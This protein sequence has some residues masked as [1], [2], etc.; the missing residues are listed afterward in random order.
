MIQKIKTFILTHKIISI[1]I[2]VVIVVGAYFIFR[3]S[4]GTETRYITEVV[5]KGSITTTVTGTGQIEASDTIT[6]SPK[7]S[8]DV[9]YV[10]VK[11]GDVVKKGKLLMS[12]DS[13]SAK[14][15]LDN[16]KLS[17]E[18][19]TTVDSLDLLKEENSLKVSYDSGWN[20]VSSYITD[21]TDLLNGMEDLY[22]SDGYLGYKNISDLDNTGKGKVSIAENNFYNA[23]KSLDDLV[24]TYKTLSRTDSNEKIKELIDK[25]YDSSVVVASAVKSTE[26]AFNYAVNS[27]EEGA[28][29][30]TT[31]SSA[32]TDITS[33][34]ST[35][36]GYVNS[37]LSISNGIEE[38][39]QSL[40]ETKAGAD[41]LDIRSAQLTVQ[42]KQDAYNDCFLYAPFDGIIASF[43][44]KVGESSGSSVGSIITEQKVATISF[45]EVDIASI[46]LGQKAVLTFDAVDGLSIDG[47]VAEMD[48]VGTVS[49]GVVTYDVTIALDKDDNR[50]KA[51]MSVNVEITTNSK[52]DILTVSSSA[53]KTK[54]GTSY[55][56]MFE[57]PLMSSESQ[58]GATSSVS[59]IRKQVTVGITDDTLT[60]IVSGLN[61]GDQIILKTTTGTSTSSSSTKSTTNI[62]GMGGGP[63][64]GG[65]AI[66]GIMH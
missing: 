37:L 16:A 10:G 15:A 27:L 42:T 58:Q 6:L 50:I 8:G 48:S 3:N 60:E 26:T 21:T 36:N 49:S 7:A 28:N 54:N 53:V 22:G 38:S 1:I 5:K 29:S 39:E 51:G 55:V 17:L 12:V 34:L 19:L 30:S 62:G 18:D 65:S 14:A 23:K 46:Q 2:L 44:A 9:T 25:A 57:T 40:A 31:A 33:W 59:P 45:N 11:A 43:T 32:R 52:Q 20:K 64:M 41:E 13:R 66:G 47:T 56:E 61:E 4:S 35:S 63:S 24:K